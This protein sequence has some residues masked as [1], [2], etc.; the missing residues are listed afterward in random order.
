MRGIGA[1]LFGI[2]TFLAPDI[3]LQ[4]LILLVAAYVIVDGIFSIINAFRS[5]EQ[6]LFG[7][8]VSRPAQRVLCPWLTLT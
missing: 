4:T 1:I 6:L 2:A 5:R 7:I 8:M 3:V